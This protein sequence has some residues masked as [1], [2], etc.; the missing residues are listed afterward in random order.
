MRVHDAAVLH[1]LAGDVLDDV[2]RDREP[3][4]G[5]CAAEPRIGGGERWDADHPSFE[6]DQRAAAVAGIDR[7]ARL[8]RVGKNDTPAL[9]HVP[10][11]GAYDPVRHAA[12]QP[13]ELPTARTMPPTSTFEESANAAVVIPRPEPIVITARS[14]GR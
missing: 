6:I 8:D 4:T 3:D 10:A 13:N 7:R 9:A 1:D 11:D 2:A 5:G 12:L 14:S